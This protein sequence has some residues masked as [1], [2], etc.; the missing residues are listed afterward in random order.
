MVLLI[1]CGACVADTFCVEIE[2]DRYRDPYLS[3]ALLRTVE[4]AVVESGHTL[5]CGEG[6]KTLRV[7]ILSFGEKPIA[8]T[9][10]QRVSTYSLDVRVRLSTEGE[11]FTVFTSVPYAIPGGSEGDIPRRRAID[12]LLDKL[13]LNILKNLRGGG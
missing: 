12:D 9:P 11:S 3:Y 2:G 1:L 4:R 8:Y 5:H 7:E 13:Y 6:S 10:Q